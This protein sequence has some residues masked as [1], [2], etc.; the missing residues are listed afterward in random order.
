MKISKLLIRNN[1][2][3][4]KGCSMPV[5]R[6]QKSKDLPMKIYESL[7]EKNMYVKHMS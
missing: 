7:V 4:L 5:L 2:D 6:C 1:L 3:F